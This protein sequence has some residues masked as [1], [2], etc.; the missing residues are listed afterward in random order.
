MATRKLPNSVA[1]FRILPTAS[2]NAYCTCFSVFIYGKKE[3]IYV[4]FFFQKSFFGGEPES[5][6][7]LHKI[8]GL[9]TNLRKFAIIKK[10]KTQINLNISG[11]WLHK[12][13][14]LILCFV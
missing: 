9:L 6:E 11:A 14:K 8:T 3:V 13:S 10:K 2:Q 1:R 4:N 12:Y 7:K 5:F